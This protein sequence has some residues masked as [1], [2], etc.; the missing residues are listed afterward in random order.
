MIGE[1]AFWGC[2]NLSEATLPE[3]LTIIG[4]QAFAY[5]KKKK[6][7]ALPSLVTHIGDDAFP[8]QVVLKV[9]PGSRAEEWA[10][11]KNVHYVY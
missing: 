3:S 2:E 11:N 9:V 5:K 8:E 4:T 10:K 6:T 1:K 7:L